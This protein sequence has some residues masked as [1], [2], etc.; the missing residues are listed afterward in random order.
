MSKNYVTREILGD[1]I[2]DSDLSSAINASW[3]KM[4]SIMDYTSNAPSFL[5]GDDSD[6]TNKNVLEHLIR[7]GGS[8]CERLLVVEDANDNNRQ[9]SFQTA[10]IDD[11]HY[12]IDLYLAGP[13]GNGSRAWTK[14]DVPA[15]R[16]SFRSMLKEQGFDK[17]AL[18]INSALGIKNHVDEFYAGESNDADN[19]VRDENENMHLYKMRIPTE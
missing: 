2:N 12:T 5:V 17:F 8:R 6:A 16:K 18:D 15:I 1:E 9:L 10:Y 11:N 19:G 7:N 14:T 3:P 4:R 13:D